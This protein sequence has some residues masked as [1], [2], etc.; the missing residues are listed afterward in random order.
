MIDVGAAVDS[1]INPFHIFGQMQDEEDIDEVS[2]NS[3][4]RAAFSSHIQFLEQFFQS[5]IP[6]LTDKEV[7]RLSDLIT[8]T[9]KNKKIGDTTDFAN[10]ESKAFP[11][12]DD[13]MGLVKLIS[14]RISTEW[15]EKFN[16]NID[17]L[18]PVFPEEFSSNAAGITGGGEFG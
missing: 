10:L 4:R 12:M 14:N 15:K 18:N 3:L 9:Y 17:Y 8:E 11:I 16:K 5:L 6:D 7:A 13:L 2:V 1:R